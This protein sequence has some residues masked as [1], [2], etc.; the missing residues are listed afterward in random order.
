MTGPDAHAP[1]PVQPVRAA[2]GVK[3]DLRDPYGFGPAA[4]I[5]AGGYFPPT[6]G[7]RAPEGPEAAGT[8]GVPG[9]DR[10]LYAVALV[11]GSMTKH[12]VPWPAAVPRAEATAACGIKV[13]V[14]D[15]SGSRVIW[16]PGVLMC[17]DCAA[18]VT[19]RV[20]REGT[21]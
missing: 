12:A 13:R 8:T 6:T 19:G 20:R 18:V 17:Q 2:E 15:I 9:Q 1:E 5:S 21:G 10:R 7:C 3:D 16:M 4:R 14:A 11:I